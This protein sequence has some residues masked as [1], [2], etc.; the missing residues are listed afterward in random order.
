MKILSFRDDFP[1]E[2]S[3][4]E[5]EVAKEIQI[6]KDTEYRSHVFSY[7][8]KTVDEAIA[9]SKPSFVLLDPPDLINFFRIIYGVIHLPDRIRG[10]R[11]GL[12]WMS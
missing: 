2:W 4:K 9:L 10:L 6:T 8:K 3:E 1:A 7:V 5:E 11:N 12:G